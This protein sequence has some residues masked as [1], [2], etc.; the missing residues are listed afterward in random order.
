MFLQDYSLPTENIDDYT[1]LR[2]LPEFFKSECQQAVLSELLWTKEGC[3]KLIVHL[4]MFDLIRRIAFIKYKGD[5]LSG[6]TLLNMISLIM[7]NPEKRKQL[8]A[9]ILAGHFPLIDHSGNKVY[10]AIDN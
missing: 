4:R 5:K 7:K 1:F 9:F 2:A 10:K 8:I 3:D 6:A